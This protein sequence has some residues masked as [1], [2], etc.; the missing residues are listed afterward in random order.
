MCSSDLAGLQDRVIQVY[1][2]LVYMDFAESAMHEV[3]GLQC[4]RYERLDPCALP[5]LYVAYN[6]GVSEPTEVFHNNLRARFEAGEPQVLEAMKKFA[7]L[8]QSA[9]EALARGDHRRLAELIDANFDTRRSI[10]RLPGGQVEMIERARRAGASA[11]F[12]IG[13]AH[14]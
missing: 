7:G 8:A 1:E 13:R 12:E 4:G 10:C 2:G 14:V 5:P 3:D 6:A 9:R 11:K